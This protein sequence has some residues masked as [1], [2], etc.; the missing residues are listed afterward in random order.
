MTPSNFPKNVQLISTTRHLFSGTGKACAAKLGYASFNLA[1]HVG[2]DA[3]VVASN[4]A[5]LIEKFSLPNTPK[6]LQQ[7]HSNIC[8][9]ALSDD[10]IGDAVVTQE[11]G[12][13]CVVMTADCLPIFACN[14]PGTQ[15]GVAHAGWQGIVNGVIESFVEQFKSRDLRVHFGPAISQAAFEV[16]EEVY[17]QFMDKDL[18][19]NQAFTAKGEKYQ[20]DIYQAAKVILNGLGVESISG[21][22]ECTYTQQDKYFSYRRDGAKSGRMAHLIWIK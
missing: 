9:Q 19:L 20:L 10:C 15:V 22:D 4:R 12:V 14:S 5:L 1:T 16:G 7:T 3:K 6:Y 2:D 11:K 8:L 13:V 21:G 17:Q 18:K